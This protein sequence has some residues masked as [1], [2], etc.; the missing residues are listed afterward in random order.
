MFPELH[1]DTEGEVE[2]LKARRKGV[3]EIINF[4][5]SKIKPGKEMKREFLN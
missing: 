4:Y 2:T 5:S 1:I 3:T